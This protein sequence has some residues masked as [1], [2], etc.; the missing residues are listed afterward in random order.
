MS[1]S[2][3]EVLA[4]DLPKPRGLGFTIRAFVDADQATDSMTRTS[5]TSF[6]VYLDEAPICCSARKKEVLKPVPLGPSLF[7]AMKACT[8][9]ICGL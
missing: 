5:R 8:D 4:K 6:L 7:T 9:Y 1:Q 3:K 2:L